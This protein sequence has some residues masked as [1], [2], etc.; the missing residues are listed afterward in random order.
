MG[1]VES[2]ATGV[3]GRFG[4]GEATGVS[5]RFGGSEATG[6][7][8]WFGEVEATG[9]S[10]R[11]CEAFV[12]MGLDAYKQTFSEGV[13][14]SGFK[15]TSCAESD[16]VFDAVLL[17]GTAFGVKDGVSSARIVIAWLADGA[18]GDDVLFARVEFDQAGDHLDDFDTVVGKDAAE[19]GVSDEGDLKEFVVVLVGFSGLFHIE[20]VVEFFGM[21]GSAVREADV[22]IGFIF[23]VGEGAQPSEMFFTEDFDGPIEGL[24]GLVVVVRIIHFPRYSG[25]MVAHDREAR[26]LA[27][28]IAAFVGRGTVSNDIT[29]TDVSFNGFFLEGFH[30]R[31]KGGE[32][33]VDIR[34]NAY[35]HRWL[36]SIAGLVGCGRFKEVS[37][38]NLSKGVELSLSNHRLCLGQRAT[39][40]RTRGDGAIETLGPPVGLEGTNRQAAS[41]GVYNTERE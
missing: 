7:I 39:T 37:R 18:D 34:K 14:Q 26:Y 13:G 6:V 15:D 2:E 40:E 1:F 11:F 36:S 29:E 30:H 21:D 20:D 16:I 28:D 19:V 32:V 27:D 5:G 38:F 3:S 35:P 9:V 10:G 22:D 12:G 25:V 31:F 4:G 17:E 33:G 8:D 41:T 23:E 24:F